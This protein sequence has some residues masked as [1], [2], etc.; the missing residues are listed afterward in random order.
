MGLGTLPKFSKK[1][2]LN[3]YAAY[4]TKDERYKYN[5]N[6]LWLLHNDFPRTYVAASYT[7]DIDLTVNYYDHVT[8]DNILSFAVRRPG[9]PQKF[10]FADDARLEFY[11]EY[12]SGF[13][14]LLT[15]LHKTYQPYAPLPSAA[16]FSDAN[17]FA[18]NVVTQS[19]LNLR[20]RYAYKEKFLNGNYYRTSLG[21]KYPIAELRIGQ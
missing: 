7:H 17:G 4:G 12:A 19:E 16:I 1:V 11:K 13:S 9:I 15:A 10:V 14:H 5:V 3:G 18:S 21:S 8:F 20:L 2:Y 6:G